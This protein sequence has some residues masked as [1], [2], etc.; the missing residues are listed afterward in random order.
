V[1]VQERYA[2]ILAPLA[3]KFNLSFNAFGRSNKLNDRRASGTLTLDEAFGHALNPAPITPTNP[4]SEPWKLLSGTI[5]SSFAT[6]KKGRES[7]E[8]IIVSPGISTGAIHPHNATA[9]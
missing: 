5:I 7:N 2:E 9:F 1:Q 8:T 3:Q 6:S 4:D